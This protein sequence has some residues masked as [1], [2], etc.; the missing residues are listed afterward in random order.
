MYDQG[1]HLGTLRNLQMQS[2]Q[3]ESREGW[4]QS[5]RPPLAI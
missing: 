2:R 4:Q 5:D 3:M 1:G